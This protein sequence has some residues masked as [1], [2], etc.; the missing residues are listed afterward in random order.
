MSDA[1]DLAFSLDA[2]GLV[3]WIDHED[4]QPVLHLSDGSQ[5]VTIESVAGP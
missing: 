2:R 5:H 3:V 4:D 1:P